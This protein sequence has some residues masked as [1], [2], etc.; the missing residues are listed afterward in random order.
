MSTASTAGVSDLM[1]RLTTVPVL[2]LVALLLTLVRLF[3]MS[4]KVTMQ[5]G[6]PSQVS[7]TARSYADVAGV[8]L[9]V[10][11]LFFLIPRPFAPQLFYI[12]SESMEPTLLGHDPG[13]NVVTGVDHTD[14]VHDH[15]VVNKL[16]YR[17]GDPQRGAI[18][19]FKAPPEADGED[20]SLGQPLR[21][22]ILIERCMA[23]PGDTIWIHDGAIFRKQAGQAD[24]TKLVEPYL[25]P[26]LPLEDPQ[27]SDAMFG[28][29]EPLT[30]APDRYF[31]M[32]DNRNDSNDSRFWGPLERTR[33]L[34]KATS[35]YAPPER[36]RSLH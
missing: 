2:V 16:A 27:R 20:K 19:V 5:P 18:L 22:N 33:I 9:C 12:P 31:V 23:I 32:G 15:I 14:S 4:R 24:F 36:I 25:D 34:G 29:H 21:E 10:F 6:G 35:I 30:L 28:V 8:L 11:V 26:K 1:A 13:H 17:M 3:L 7:P